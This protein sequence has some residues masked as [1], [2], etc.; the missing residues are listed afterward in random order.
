M[1]RLMFS[2]GDN[3]TVVS[4]IRE[5]E[6]S[7]GRNTSRDCMSI[8]DK[9][10]AQ[11]LCGVVVETEEARGYGRFLR[12]IYK[13]DFGDKSLPYYGNSWFHEEWIYRTEDMHDAYE[14][15]KLDDF[16]SEF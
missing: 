10:W 1:G 11:G 9:T 13:V 3:V 5:I 7:A 14:S 16:L 4:D 2:I 8:G 12:D 6:E 15:T